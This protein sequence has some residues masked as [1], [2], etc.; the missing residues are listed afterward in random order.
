MP[1]T[2]GIPAPDLYWGRRSSTLRYMRRAMLP[3]KGKLRRTT[4]LKAPQ[5]SLS[6]VVACRSLPPVQLVVPCLQ[7]V[8]V[9]D[10]VFDGTVALLSS[11]ARVMGQEGRSN[12]LKRC[13]RAT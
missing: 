11:L 12:G 13:I 9:P 2:I 8:Q 3:Y 6:Y 5:S 1:C 10:P 7:A 4:S